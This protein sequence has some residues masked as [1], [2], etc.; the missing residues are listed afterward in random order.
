MVVLA[1]LAGGAPAQ[2]WGPTAQQVIV[3]KAIETLPKGI[4]S[5]YK[6]HRFEMSSLALEPTFP[7]DG[8]ERR[9]AVDRLM[10][11]PFAD[12]PHTEKALKTRFPDQADGLGRLPWLVQESYLQLKE[13]FKSGDKV[14]IL[15]ESDRLALLV[16]DLHNPLALSENADGQKT[17][18][19]GLWIRFGVKFP[20]AMKDRLK[21]RPDAANFLDNPDEY[22]FSIIEG[23]YVWLD[24][25]LYADTLARRGKPGYGEIYFESFEIR[26][27]AY[28]SDRLAR[29]AEDAGSYWYTAWTA[30]GRPELK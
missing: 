9:F 25:V 8:P 12:L 14:K 10:P 5:F 3:Q 23:T 30:A 11:W 26:A 16:A 13:A 28:L 2:A 19:H 21:V 6:N 4:Q 7:E 15:S 22:V 18:Q 1:V 27:S 29:A 20:E 24:N 17:G